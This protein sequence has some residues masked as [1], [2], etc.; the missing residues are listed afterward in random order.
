[1][2][3]IAGMF[4]HH[5]RSRCQVFFYSYDATPDNPIRR[6]L[7]SDVEVFR[8]VAQASDKEIVQIARR[9]N[10]D[11]AIDLKGY[12]V[13]TRVPIFAHRLARHQ[14]SLLGYPSSL[15]ADFMDYIVADYTAIPPEYEAFYSEHVLRMP[16][17]YFMNDDQRPIDPRQFSRAELGLPDDAVVFCCFNAAHKICSTV[18]SRW[19]EILR[20]VDGSVLWLLNETDIAQRNLRATAR[21]QGA[22]P[23]R[24]IFAER[25]PSPLHLA[26]HA[27][28]DLFLDTLAYNAHT[29]ACDALWAGVPV[30]TLPGQQFPA[31]VG[32]SV[33]AAHGMSE[34]IV[35]SPACYVEKAIQLGK[36]RSALKALKEKTG[37]KRVSKLFDT[38]QY[39]ADF[40]DLLHSI[41]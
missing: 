12:T 2:H 36:N 5:D 32:A 24:L 13:Q 22:A 35:D 40:E 19:M 37:V 39:V 38:K 30:L 14:V 29:T 17:S 18:F 11:V 1:M 31:R 21:A 25:M 41:T 6:K 23:E 26:R 34:M 27:Q 28:A 16:N 3:L 7:A 4:A 15:G 8:D 33:V 9:D 10:L 20:Q